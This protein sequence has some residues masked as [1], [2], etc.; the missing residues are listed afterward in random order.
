MVMVMVTVMVMVMVMGDKQIDS[1]IVLQVS[2]MLFDIDHLSEFELAFSFHRDET[3]KQDSQSNRGQDK[4]G[5]NAKGTYRGS[6]IQSYQTSLFDKLRL[7]LKG[8]LVKGQFVDDDTV[9]VAFCLLKHSP[10]SRR[11]RSRGFE[12]SGYRQKYKHASR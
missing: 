10:G 9:K 3:F 11:D 6:N 5:K 7:L 4:K 2:S 1:H 12:R 8:K